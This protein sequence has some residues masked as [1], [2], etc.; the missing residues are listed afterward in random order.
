MTGAP[1]TDK[2][3]DPARVDAVLEQVG[4]D[5]RDGDAGRTLAV[6]LL[7]RDLRRQAEGRVAERTCT[8]NWP[9]RARGSGVGTGGVRAHLLRR[10]HACGLGT[11]CAEEAKELGAARAVLGTSTINR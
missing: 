7:R 5:E 11:G 10:V 8:L 9:R 1:P 3:V 6:A 2:D 4:E